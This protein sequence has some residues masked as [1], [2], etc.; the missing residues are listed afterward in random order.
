MDRV[1]RTLLVAV[2]IGVCAWALLRWPR[3]DT[4]ETGRTAEYPELRPR[5]YAASEPDTT[6]AVKAT[7]E[8]LGWSFVGAGRGPSGSEIQA[9]ARGTVLPTEHEVAIRIQRT[10]PRTR[11]SV[12]AHSRTFQ[13]D[14]GEDARV[15]E[16]FLG[17]LDSEMAAR[18]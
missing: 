9:T 14:F 11:V 10:G 7:L 13:W 1:L 12:R 16:R 4:V 17:A 3:I 5:D 18:R 6:R 8:R 2:A 15:I